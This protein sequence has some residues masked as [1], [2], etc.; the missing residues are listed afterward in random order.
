MYKDFFNLQ[1]MP[2]T[3]SPDPRYM[4]LTGQHAE[5][6]AKCQYVINQRSG[7]A[8]V[9]GDVGTGKTTVARRLY[10]I[11]SGDDQFELAML[12]TPNLKTDTAFLRK[13]MQQF[14]VQ[15]KRSYAASEGALQEYAFR[16][17]QEGKTLVLMVDEA[18]D[19]TVRMFKVIRAMLNFETNSAKFI[20][21]ILFGQAELAAILDMRGM[22][23]IKSRVSMFGAL[24]SLTSTD[25]EDV[26]QYRWETAGG[27]RHPFSPRAVQQIYKLSQGLPREVIKLCN[28]SLLR[29]AAQEIHEVNEFMVIQAAKELRLK[30]NS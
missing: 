2:Y 12:I 30:E 11:L 9:S 3:I 27:I 17:A 15:P 26:I 24:S 1:E 6:L 19:L 10:E 21:V 23:A 28:E 4:Y 5:A 29:A 20:Q 25:A 18:Q 14:G 13:I 16:R 8:V 7:L 22:R